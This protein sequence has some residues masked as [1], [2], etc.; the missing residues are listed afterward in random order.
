MR[1]RAD[2]AKNAPPKRGKVVVFVME[3]TAS[4]AWGNG[5]LLAVV[6]FVADKA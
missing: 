5:V 1:L 6:N 4:A 3:L 2:G